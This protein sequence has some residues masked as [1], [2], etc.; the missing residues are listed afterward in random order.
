MSQRCHAMTLKGIQCARSTKNGQYCNV[1]S[2]SNTRS[3]QNPE[4]VPLRRNVPR[5]PKALKSRC[6]ELTNA[7]ECGQEQACKWNTKGLFRDKPKCTSKYGKLY[8][9][10]AREQ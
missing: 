4:H 8:K 3:V 10:W 6:K 2:G 1:H 9:D 5:S 7:D